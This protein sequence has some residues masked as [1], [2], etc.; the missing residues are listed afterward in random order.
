MGGIA[1]DGSGEDAAA[2]SFPDDGAV[3][4][5]KRPRGSSSSPFPLK[6][7]GT[8]ALEGGGF[9]GLGG[10]FE[11]GAGGEFE[12]G[13]L[14]GTGLGTEKGSRKEVVFFFLQAGQMGG[15]ISTSRQSAQKFF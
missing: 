11:N 4:C 14:E 13:I 2:G 9:T 5:L 10:G 12:N 3:D 8:D 1:F 6:S 7:K 15:P